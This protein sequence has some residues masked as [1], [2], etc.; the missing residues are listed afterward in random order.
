MASLISVTGILFQVSWSEMRP[1]LDG[2]SRKLY[3]VETTKYDL[4]QN[5]VA[6]QLVAIDG[7]VIYQCTLETGSSDKTDWES[8]KSTCRPYK[9]PRQR[10][11]G[12]Y[13]IGK[14]PGI[15][16]SDPQYIEIPMQTIAQTDEYTWEASQ[17]YSVR[18]Q[19]LRLKIKD[20]GEGDTIDLRFVSDGSVPVLGP[21]G[22]LLQQF[23]PVD[24]PDGNGWKTEELDH[25]DGVSKLMPS[26]GTGIRI[27]FAYVADSTDTRKVKVRAT[28]HV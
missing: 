19:G 26:Q 10:D 11:D 22:T 27:E 16:E 15:E 17:L 25:F 1:L 2:T 6:T 4:E 12:A 24:T 14:D 23:G 8:I 18:L 9:G 20:G 5:E 13:V 3:Y 7:Q 28:A 21:N